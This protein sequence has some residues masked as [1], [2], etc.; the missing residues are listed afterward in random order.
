MKWLA[1][2]FGSIVALASSVAAVAA[3]RTVTF[4]V[5]NMT[6]ASC[7]FIVRQSMAAVRGVDRVRVSLEKRTATVTFDDAKTTPDAIAAASAKAGFPA[8]PSRQ[9][10]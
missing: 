3:E 1:T 4:A 5:E 10:S 2:A 7:P 6:C 9:G 8:N